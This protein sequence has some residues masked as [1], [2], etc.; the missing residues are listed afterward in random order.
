MVIASP[1]ENPKN[2]G[3]PPKSK[4]GKIR[5]FSVRAARGKGGDVSLT[6]K[7]SRWEMAISPIRFPAKQWPDHR[8]DQRRYLGGIIG[9]V[10]RDFDGVDSDEP[11]GEVWSRLLDKALSAASEVVLPAVP[12][13]G[14]FLG[15]VGDCWPRLTL[16]GV[17]YRHA[18]RGVVVLT[19]RC[20]PVDSDW[21]VC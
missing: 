11:L 2:Q 20:W 17:S 19:G 8:V 12:A 14:I 16:D 1:R 4:V 18:S 13:D 10:V 9:V 7:L 6:I 15:R 21:F 5:D 3:L